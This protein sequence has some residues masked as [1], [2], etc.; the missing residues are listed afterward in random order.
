MSPRL[1]VKLNKDFDKA[2][3]DEFLNRSEAGVDFGVGIVK[4]HPKLLPAQKALEK[5]FPI[6]KID[7]YF[8]AYYKTNDE[9]LQESVKKAQTDW[10]KISEKFYKACDK[11]FDKHFWPK[12]KYEAYLSIIDCNPRFLHNKT[13]QVFWKHK[14]GFVFMA[15]HEMLHFLFFDLVEKLFPNI[16]INTQKMWEISEVFNGLIMQE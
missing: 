8:D 6:K 2:I 10:D 13:F 12:G 7:K 15:M 1:V 14:K 3:C 9:E 4:I 5:Q 11:Y 16:N